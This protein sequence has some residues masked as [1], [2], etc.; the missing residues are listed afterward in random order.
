MRSDNARRKSIEGGK[1]QTIEIAEREPLGRISSQHV[2][3]MAQRW[4]R[5]QAKLFI[6]TI[7]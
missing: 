3:L 6:G 7:R 4:D 2:E 1:D 5:P